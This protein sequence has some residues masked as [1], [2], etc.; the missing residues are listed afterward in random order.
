MMVTEDKW[1][2]VRLTLLGCHGN[3]SFSLAPTDANAF[4]DVPEPLQCL[5]P[6]AFEQL[7][8]SFLTT[9]LRGG[10][11]RR[12]PPR[13]S[14]RWQNQSDGEAVNQH[15]L[16]IR[17]PWSFALRRSTAFFRGSCRVNVSEKVPSQFSL[18]WEIVWDSPSMKKRRTVYLGVSR[19]GY[20]SWSS[21]AKIADWRT[22][23]EA[24][25]SRA[26]VLSEPEFSTLLRGD[27]L[28]R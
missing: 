15:I 19:S 23:T 24:L 10:P 7:R 8:S 21:A 3:T 11:L 12:N 20:E 4:R 6:W 16:P 14:R 17:L 9:D 26:R 28:P 13:G 27:H 18:W 22:R 2:I 5:L 1:K 25:T